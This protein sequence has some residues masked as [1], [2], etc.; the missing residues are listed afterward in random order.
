MGISFVCSLRLAPP[1][2]EVG[3]VSPGLEL[4]LEPLRKPWGLAQRTVPFSG[5]NEI[6]HKPRIEI[7]SQSWKIMS[8]QWVTTPGSNS[9]PV[10][11]PVVQHHIQAIHLLVLMTITWGI[12]HPPFL[13]KPRCGDMKNRKWGAR[14]GPAWYKNR[15]ILGQNWLE[16]KG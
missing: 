6:C 2:A 14:L 3:T 12:R 10:L 15:P 16:S 5:I 7:V 8:Q 9:G 13:R 1:A 11:V 4:W